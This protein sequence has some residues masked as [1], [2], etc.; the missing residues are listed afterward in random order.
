M[1]PAALLRAL[2]LAAMLL[3]SPAR[4]VRQA[5]R[6]NVVLILTDDQDVCLGGMVT[7]RRG[8]RGRRQ[9]GEGRAVGR[10]S[11]RPGGRRA[12]P[13]PAGQGLPAASGRAAP[14]R[15]VTVGLRGM[16]GARGE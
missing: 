8:A 9:R 13:S 14:E 16:S 15:S 11:L 6:P 12:G 1:S 2:P 7:L 4:A 5:R 3:L 10:G